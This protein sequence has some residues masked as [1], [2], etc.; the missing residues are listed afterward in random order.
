MSTTAKIQHKG[1][2][3]IPTHLRDQAGLAQGDLVELSFQRGKIVIT[4]KLAID[5]S[6]FPNADDDYT[7]EQR[8]I[9]DARLAESEDDHKNGRT[10]GPF[11]TADEAIK[12]PHKEL[13]TRK[14]GK[15]MTK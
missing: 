8:R 11:E 13:R 15:L 1:P 6:A 9:V 14:A 2:V 3:T 10:R 12:F 4:P 5:R 7:P